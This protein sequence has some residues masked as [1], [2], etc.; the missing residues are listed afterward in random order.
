MNDTP[1]NPCLKCHGTGILTDGLVRARC[2]HC[3]GRGKY[4]PEHIRLLD[5]PAP[6]PVT[7]RDCATHLRQPHRP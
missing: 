2:F 4:D 6:N 3:E 5:T 7:G 1:E